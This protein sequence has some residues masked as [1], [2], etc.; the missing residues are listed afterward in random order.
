[1]AQ[2]AHID[3]AHGI[4]GSIACSCCEDGEEKFGEI[5]VT[6]HHMSR[7]VI[8]LCKVYLAAYLEHWFQTASRSPGL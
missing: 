6:C 2:R 5:K 7:D 3:Y 1:M 4:L 8:W